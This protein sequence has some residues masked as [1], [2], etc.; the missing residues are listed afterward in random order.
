VG[1]VGAAAAGWVN[2]LVAAVLMPFSSALVV[3]GASRVEAAVQ[4]SEA[5][6]PRSEAA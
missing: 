3:W 5:A 6:V 4:A 2:P 1:A